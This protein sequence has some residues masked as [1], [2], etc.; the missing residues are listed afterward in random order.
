SDIFAGVVQTHNTGQIEGV[1]SKIM[2][3]END[4]VGVAGYLLTEFGNSS[5]NQL[6]YKS[7][8]ASLLDSSYTGDI[9]RQ[10]I[11]QTCNEYGW[12]QTSGSQNQPFGTKFPVTLYIQMCQDLYGEQFTNEF[13]NN[14][15]AATNELFGGLE[16]N[17]ENVY[18]THG[19][20]DPWRAMGI[21]DEEQATILPLYAHCKDFGSISDSD[22]A[23][24]RA[25]KLK[26]AELVRKWLG[27]DNA[28]NKTES[29]AG[30][31][32]MHPV[33][34]EDSPGDTNIPFTYPLNPTELIPF[35]LWSDPIET[36]HFPG[37]RLSI[38]QILNGNTIRILCMVGRVL[39][40]LVQCLRRKDIA[41][42]KQQ[43]KYSNAYRT[44]TSKADSY[45]KC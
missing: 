37:L 32:P 8:I 23:E 10:W 29:Y 9:M 30:Y 31:T 13:I 21:H 15:V 44:E 35:S 27:V 38:I 2:E 6:S 40:S 16:P 20:L 1:C 18:F 33:Y 3:G 19:Q 36:E 12:Y 28:N 7:I 41:I 5:C 43:Q 4:I 42:T 34:E 14:Q 11:Y 39:N 45:T 26:I 25:S 24:L 22:T 17:V